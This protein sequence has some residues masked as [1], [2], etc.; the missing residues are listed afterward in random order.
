MVKKSLKIKIIFSLLAGIELVFCF[1]PLGSIPLGVMV[2]TLSCVPVI[3]TSL[4]LGPMYGG[5]M[6]FLFGFFSFIVWT[7]MPPNPA[8]AFIWT[9]FYNLAGMH[10]NAFSLIICFIPRIFTGILPSL[11][12]RKFKKEDMKQ[13]TTVAVIASVI[14]SLTNTL[15]VLLGIWLFFGRSYEAIYIEQ[16]GVKTTILALIGITVLT[17]GIPECIV[18]GVV[19]PIITKVLKLKK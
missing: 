14:G 13:K 19:C 11:I 18:C 5:M 4:V 8:F 6:G 1:T 17:N 3:I 10:G 9:P 16:T 7:F 15:L 12:Y 2:A